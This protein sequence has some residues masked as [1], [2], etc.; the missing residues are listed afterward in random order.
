MIGI[1]ETLGYVIVAGTAAQMALGLYGTWR[2]GYLERRSFAAEARLFERRVELSLRRAEA[3]RDLA[4][5]SWSGFRKLKVVRKV[6]EAEDV[7]S[8]ELVA[9]NGRP[10]PRYLPGQFLTFQF[11]L[12]DRSKPLVRCYSLS[13]APSDGGRYRISVKKVP[14]PEGAACD[15]G[16]VSGYLNDVVREG[17]ILDVRGPTGAF[18][19]DPASDQPIVLI[20]GGIGITPLLSML[21]AMCDGQTEREIR[22]FY[23]VRNRDQHAFAEHIAGL[24]RLYPTLHVVTC[25]SRPTEACV[26][27]RDYDRPGRIDLALLR[28]TLPS[29]NYLFYLCGPAPMMESVAGGLRDW[30]VPSEDI[31]VEAF[32]A[33]TAHRQPTERPAAEAKP[34][35]EVR[36]DRSGKTLNWDGS[37]GSILALAESN[38]VA[39]E[40]GCRAGHC[41]TCIVAI[42]AG[43][44]DYVAEPAVVPE[45]G[46]CLA[47]MAVPRDR[48]I[49]DA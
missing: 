3:E 46:T 1:L 30:G 13:D 35:V 43:A 20:A 38:G 5:N 17:D 16:I 8:L 37:A 22:L 24:R 2:R 31:R 21:N 26:L 9:H 4:V 7:H 14:A 28:D 44:V 39:L 40:S 48:L 42:K 27:G 34:G 49:L 12:P 18:T 25:Y 47:C 45:P 32:G 33:A 41:G 15:P 10:L 6:R 11:R 19:G 29:T 23:G 36:F